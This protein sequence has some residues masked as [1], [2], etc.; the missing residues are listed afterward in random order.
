M[1]LLEAWG[2]ASDSREAGLW[3][4][5]GGEAERGGGALWSVAWEEGAG[6]VPKERGGLGAV[7]GKA[8]A[9]RPGGGRLL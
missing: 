1:T 2:V 7:H 4:R 3:R 8:E 6:P 9:S 5:G